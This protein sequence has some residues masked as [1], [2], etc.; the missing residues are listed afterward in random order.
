MTN[1]ELDTEGFLKSPASRPAAW[2]SILDEDRVSLCQSPLPDD[3]SASDAFLVNVA[4][5]MLAESR[6]TEDRRELQAASVVSVDEAKRDRK[7]Q[8]TK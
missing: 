3:Y 8:V 2:P 6:G 7:E 4:R 5:S 1:T